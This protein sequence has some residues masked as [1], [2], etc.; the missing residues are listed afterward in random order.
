MVSGMINADPGAEVFVNEFARAVTQ[1]DHDAVEELLEMIADLEVDSAVSVVNALLRRCGAEIISAIVS[2]TALAQSAHGRWLDVLCQLNMCM[3][4]LLVYAQNSG[5][6]INMTQRMIMFVQSPGS[7]RDDASLVA[8]TA[9]ASV[10]LLTSTDVESYFK[11]PEPEEESLRAFLGH[12]VVEQLAKSLADCAL[13]CLRN[14]MIKAGDNIL[15]ELAGSREI[16]EQDFGLANKEDSSEEEEEEQSNFPCALSPE[17]LLGYTC[18]V[19]RVLSDLGRT[20]ALKNLLECSD[21]LRALWI[22]IGRYASENDV[23]E[24]L[25]RMDTMESTV[26]SS[27][28]SEYEKACVLARVWLVRAGV[29]RG[30]S[31]DTNYF[32]LVQ[33][34]TE[35]L[36]PSA[37][38]LSFGVTRNHSDQQSETVC[39]IEKPSHVSPLRVGQAALADLLR[40]APREDA[41]LAA[42]ALSVVTPVIKE[43][44]RA[45]RELVRLMTEHPDARVRVHDSLADY[46]GDALRV[47]L[48]A[49]L[50]FPVDMA[51]HA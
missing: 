48:A 39:S 40:V 45:R 5:L 15:R 46:V 19:T 4:A 18:E 23:S 32:A 14:G 24:V 47:V 34:L 13:F 21:G 6:L 26:E 9:L 51:V 7:N 42:P 38:R 41:T 27:D 35:L 44:D 12:D 28:Q 33:K 29:L 22:R 2:G 30:T 50:V 25:T 10:A 49:T 3:P 16:V 43:A 20:D 31:Y 36:K 37:Q 17:T 1:E 8:A 11:E